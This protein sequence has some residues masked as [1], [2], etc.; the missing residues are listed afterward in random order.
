M[1]EYNASTK[2]GQQLISMGGKCFW[3][4]LDRIYTRWSEQK[5]KASERCFEEY[6]SDMNSHDF[7]IGNAN[8]FCFTCSWLTVKDGEEIMRIETKDNS[9]LVWLER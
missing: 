4:S 5:Q 3:S 1:R 8:T 9:Y 7:G 6:A 2:R